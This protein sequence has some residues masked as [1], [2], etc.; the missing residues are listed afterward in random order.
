MPKVSVIIPVYN[1][2]KYLRECLDSVVNQT[3][4]DIEIICVNDCSPDNSLAILEE[5]K[6]KDNRIKIIDLKENGGLGNARNVAIKEVTAE[7]I[8]FLD[9]DD[10]FELNACELAYNQI[11]KNNND[12]VIF[13]TYIHSMNTNKKRNCV[14]KLS[15]FN[16]IKGKTKAKLFEIKTPYFGNAECWYKIYNTKFYKE[17][18]LEFDRGAFEDQRFNVKILTLAKSVS[19]LDEPLYNYRRRDD[20]ITA[21]SSNWKDF[22]SAKKRAYE[23]MKTIEL[24]SKRT[25]KLF[26]ACLVESMLFYF[27]RYTKID[28]NILGEFYIEL[29]KF[30]SQ[31][32]AENDFSE[33]KN[34][35]DYAIFDLIAK[36]ETYRKFKI[37]KLLYVDMFSAR[38]NGSYLRIV[39]FGIKLKKRLKKIRKS[40]LMSICSANMHFNDLKIDVLNKVANN[41]ECYKTFSKTNNSNEILLNS[42]N[43]LGKFHFISNMG[44]LGDIAIA[45]SC[46][47]FFDANNLEYKVVDMSRK[48]ERKINKPFNLVYGGGGIFV[49]Y[50][51]KSYQNILKVFKSKNL[52][53]AVILPISLYDCPDVLETFDER[54]TVYCREQQTYDYCVANNKKAKFILAD[55]MVFGLNLEFYYEDKYDKENLEKFFKK[56]DVSK[57]AYLKEKVYPYF[58]KTL[59]I[60]NFVK[61]NKTQNVGYFYRIDNESTNDFD[62]KDSL[63]DI[64]LAANTNCADK[65]LCVM[66]LRQFLKTLDAFS[67]IVTDR[68]HVGIC[69]MLLGK[70]VYMLDNSYKK[71]SN[72]YN[73]SMLN[74]SKVR[75][76]SNIEELNEISSK[77]EKYHEKIE[78]YSFSDFIAEWASIKN[79]FGPEKGFW[80]KNV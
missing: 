20:S 36:N 18:N 6:A 27:S 52:K 53:Q 77:N 79:E 51:K 42:I 57:L 66:F 26:V 73:K 68:L 38:Y 56:R 29:H 2:E 13:G 5:Y 75:L 46:Y 74:N 55:D 54:F 10:W 34:Y 48:K 63:V 78:D 41:S 72:V 22:V 24:P 15:Q 31:L 67:T 21:I 71:L 32:K 61:M 33:I 8:M 69:A 39:I 4:S 9:S 25:Q 64:S 47:Q 23:L 28:E 16:E 80:R 65:A 76:V 19:V 50:Y 7:T 44:N 11:T 17:N 58:I 14:E 40:K 35:I 59:E 1:V 49:K 30:F 3:L 12:F 62:T 37:K 45:C 43:G 60:L 70:N